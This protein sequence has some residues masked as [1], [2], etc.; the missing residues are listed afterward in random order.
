MTDKPWWQRIR[1]WWRKRWGVVPEYDRG[2]V[3]LQRC[4]GDGAPLPRGY[5]VAWWRPQSLEA[6]CYPVGLH[7]LLSYLHE[8]WVRLR[9]WRAPQL[10]VEWVERGRDEE[11]KRTERAVEFWRDRCE[12]SLTD[13]GERHKSELRAYRSAFAAIALANG[14]QIRIPRRAIASIAPGCEISTF[15]DPASGDIVLTVKLSD[16]KDTQP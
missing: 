12:R 10:D 14:G 2:L 11:R 16:A 7:V 4:V 5:A 3:R 8:A 9:A 15:E 13:A 1:E 6:V